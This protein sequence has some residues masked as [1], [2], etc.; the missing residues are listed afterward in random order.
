MLELERLFEQRYFACAKD[1]DTFREQWTRAMAVV[2][3]ATGL[4]HFD[5]AVTSWVMPSKR[6]VLAE[7]V[8]AGSWRTVDHHVAHALH[9]VHDAPFEHPL[10]F[11][12]DGGGNDG[13]FRVFRFEKRTNTLVPVA[14]LALNLGTPYRALGTTMAEVTGRQPQP[15][16]GHLSL[17]GKLMAYA[18]LGVPRPEWMSAVEDY[19]RHYQ[20]PTQALYSLG[21]ALDLELESDSLSRDDAHTLSATS[22]AVFESLLEE[23]VEAHLD[24]SVDGVVLTGGCALNVVANERIRRRVGYPVHVP[25]APNDAGISVGALW[26]VESPTEPPSVFAGLD[27]VQDVTA[28]EVVG[29]GGRRLP[30]DVVARLILEGAIIGIAEGRAELGPRAL[31]NRSIVARPDRPALRERINDRIKSREWY[32]PVAPAVLASAA[33]QFFEDPPRSPFMSFA[34]R[35]RDSERERLAGAVHVDGTAR[36][37]MVADES[38]VLGTLLIALQ[39]LGA[40]PCVLNTSFNVRGRPLLQRTSAALEVLDGTDLDF[41]WLDGWL[42]PRSTAV[43]DRFTKN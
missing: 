18:A 13:T 27:L 33:H 12:F 23:A 31:G 15:R 9:G 22:Q 24:A 43:R 16:A 26:S 11:S 36:V 14:L 6:R 8:S 35:V 40:P 32:R 2:R 20:E 21:E 17:A 4:E 1:D 5:V 19:Y 39:H 42:I 37:Q 38:C 10:V 3:E 30:I 41:A 7:V 29:R 34:V 28:S 25:P